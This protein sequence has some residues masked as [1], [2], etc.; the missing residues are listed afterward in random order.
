[1]TKTLMNKLIEILFRK[2]TDSWDNNILVSVRIDL[3]NFELNIVKVVSS[4]VG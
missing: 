2:S 1:M 3:D 4:L